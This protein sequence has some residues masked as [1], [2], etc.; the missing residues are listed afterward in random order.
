[1]KVLHSS[2]NVALNLRLESSG[3]RQHEATS[4]AL[5]AGSSGVMTR[6]AGICGP[7]VLDVVHAASNK[8]PLDNV[9]RRSNDAAEVVARQV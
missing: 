6:K 4:Y 9:S 5:T 1:M 2:D 3:G 7:P 8:L